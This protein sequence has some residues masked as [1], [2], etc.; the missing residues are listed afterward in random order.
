MN[1]N[2]W[3]LNAPL[4]LALEYFRVNGSCLKLARAASLPWVERIYGDS[5]KRKLL[6]VAHFPL[7]SA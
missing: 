7:L 2:H 6:L 5:E 3:Y 4:N 1:V